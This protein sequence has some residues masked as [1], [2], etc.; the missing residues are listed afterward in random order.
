M[1][2]RFTKKKS[3]KAKVVRNFE[4]EYVPE[5]LTLLAD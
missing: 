1:R 4:G 5:V 3:W 2:F